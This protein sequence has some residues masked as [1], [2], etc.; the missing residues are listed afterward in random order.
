MNW[1]KI[2]GDNPDAEQQYVN[3]IFDGLHDYKGFNLI[4]GKIEEKEEDS[5]LWHISNYNPGN[6]PVEFCN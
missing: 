6:F 1:V 3:D 2:E 4:F 5:V